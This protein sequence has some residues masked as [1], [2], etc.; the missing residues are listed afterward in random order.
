MSATAAIETERAPAKRAAHTTGALAGLAFA[1]CFLAGVATLDIPEG[2]SDRELVAWWS[3]S[4]HQTTAV[5][6]MY[7]FVLAGLCFLVFLGKLRSRL[8]LA[9]GGR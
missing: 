4:R 9:E 5:V 1:L 6:S 7:L 8:L 3:D 2:A